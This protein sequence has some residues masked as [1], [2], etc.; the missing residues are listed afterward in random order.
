MKKLVSALAWCLLALL[1]LLP[2][3]RLLC[4]AL[5][6]RLTL[7]RAWIY[8]LVLTVLSAG[9]LVA[10]IAAEDRES[11][12]K[13]GAT[14]DA[15]AKTAP[16]PMGPR[17]LY[18]LLPASVLNGVSLLFQLNGPII[19][20]FILATVFI[21]GILNFQARRSP[22]LR[23]LSLSLAGLLTVPLALLG[24]VT[25]F[26]NV[27]EDTVVQRLP[28]PAGSCYA[29]LID[30]DQGALGGSTY[31]E[32]CPRGLTGEYGVRVARWIY[33]GNWGEF[34]DMELRWKDETCLE[35]S[36]K[37]YPIP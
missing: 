6:Y 31:V 21:C 27:G 22:V 34:R 30:D 35:I 19:I 23:S 4:F 29:E 9:A 10:A 33:A 14:P 17:V 26:F 13:G 12:E 25:V 20:L 7:T 8:A 18:A 32:V 24:M 5:G 16:E 11:R 36:G 2:A 37:E 28:S 3:A 1:L 15:S